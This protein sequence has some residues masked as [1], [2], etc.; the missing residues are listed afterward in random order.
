[1]IRA[2]PSMI[3][4]GPNIRAVPSPG[5]PARLPARLHS[6]TI[7]APPRHLCVQSAPSQPLP[8]A[9]YARGADDALPPG[10]V[11]RLGLARRGGYP[12]PLLRHRTRRAHRRQRERHWVLPHG[13]RRHRGRCE[14]RARDRLLRRHCPQRRPSRGRKHRQLRNDARCRTGQTTRRLPA[15]QPQG[16]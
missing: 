3:R 12:R 2:G 5:L 16:F 1:M 7:L 11:H 9:E 13:R 15:S 4:A 8:G 10:L 14:P 6:R